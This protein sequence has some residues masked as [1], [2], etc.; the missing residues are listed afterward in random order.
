MLRFCWLGL[1]LM[2]A[3]LGCSTA[4]DDDDGSPSDDD[5]ATT[6]DDDDD[7][8]GDDDDDATGDDDDS[9]SD[10]DDDTTATPTPPELTIACSAT[11]DDVYVTP[12][13]LPPWDETV[14]GD[15]VRCSLDEVLSVSMLRDE[16][17]GVGVEDV[18]PIAGATVYRIA[19]RTTRWEGVEGISSARLYLPDTL[20]GGEPLPVVV[21]NHGTVGLAD[22]CAPSKYPTISAEMTL[23]FAGSGFVVIAPDYAGL[24]TDG[25]Q[26]YGDNADT[27]HSSLDAA[28]AVRNIVTPQSL[29]PGTLGVGH[30]QGGGASLSMHAFADDY[31]DGDL[32]G[33]VSFAP[34]WPTDTDSIYWVSHFPNLVLWSVATALP[35]GLQM[36]AD[37]ANHV[38]PGHEVDYFDAS[39]AADLADLVENQCV[40]SLSVQMPLLT[41]TF[42]NALDEAF[43][44]TVAACTEGSASCAPPG[45]GYV[46]RA[47]ANIVPLDPAS[48]PILFVAGMLDERSTPADVAC[49]VESAVDDGAQVQ[50]CTDAGAEHMDVTTRQASFAVEWA[51]ALA[52]GAPLPPCAESDLPACE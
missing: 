24:G 16:L 46:E 25:I 30:S 17:V 49:I 10:D 1:A 52:L 9:S 29:A 2:W 45:Q 32:L 7:A 20:A 14:L 47:E 48:G 18:E 23:A 19:F 5:S 51:T 36:Y 31:G 38:G 21:V 8:T 22:H 34:G 11:I 15:V 28:R 50:A 39:I 40:L 3:F 42:G 6:D 41:T 4:A 44:E 13:G 33:I 43:I 12:Q 37:A 26:G 27:A 35:V